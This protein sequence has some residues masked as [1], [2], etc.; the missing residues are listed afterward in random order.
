MLAISLE[1]C[2]RARWPLA[3]LALVL[4]FTA[5]PSPAAKDLPVKGGGWQRVSWKSHGEAEAGVAVDGGSGTAFRLYDDDWNDIRLVRRVRV[6]AGRFYRF[7]ARIRTEDVIGKVG[8]NLSVDGTYNR[9]RPG[10]TGTTGWTRVEQVFRATAS[11]RLAFALRLG[12]WNATARGTAW[13]DRVELEEL[14]SWGGSYEPVR[15]SPPQVRTTTAPPRLLAL[16]FFV[17]F[18][19]GGLAWL[20]RQPLALVTPPAGMGVPAR[21]AGFW[22]LLAAG[23]AVRLLFV[24]PPGPWVVPPA[25]ESWALYL[26]GFFG[27]GV[28]NPPAGV[29]VPP[30]LWLYWLGL[31]GSV[32]KAMVL[33]NSRAFA[34]LLQLP[35]VAIELVAVAAVL[36]RLRSG[37]T[38]G[39]YWA[40]AAF[41]VL[42]PG[43]L[44]A[45][46]LAADPAA[47]GAGLVL[48]SLLVVPGTRPV[49]RGM[50]FGA[51]IAAAPPMLWLAVPVVL[52]SWQRFGA[53]SAA[54]LATAAL[55][56]SGA[57][58]FPV[59]SF[60]EGETLAGFAALPAAGVAGGMLVVSG[61][62]LYLASVLVFVRRTTVQAAF[63]QESGPPGPLAGILAVTLT[64]MAAVTGPVSPLLWLA[65]LASGLLLAGNR[66][67][68]WTFFLLGLL[69]SWY[70][71][72]GY[73]YTAI[74][75]A[76]LPADSVV[77]AVLRSGIAALAIVS[78]WAILQPAPVVAA[79]SRWRARARELADSAKGL[80]RPPSARPRVPFRV[81]WFDLLLLTA[82]WAAGL[83]LVAHDMGERVYP[84]NAYRVGETS[85]VFEAVLR[86]PASLGEVRV[87][88]GANGFGDVRFEIEGEDGWEPLW[89]A[90]GGRLRYKGS[91][92]ERRS[93][94]KQLWRR[95]RLDQPVERVRLTLSGAGLEINEIVF[96]DKSREPL[97]P[98]VLEPREPAG[99]PVPASTHPLF[100]ESDRITAEKGYRA[101]TYWDEV[102][103][104][105]SGYELAN[106][107]TPYEK[108]HPP[109][110]K[111]LIAWGVDL[112]GMTP[113]GWRFMDAL[114]V[115][116]LPVLLWVA[117]RGIF[118][119]RLAAWWAAFLA[120]F[121]LMFFV[122]G[123]WAN[124]DTFLTVFLTVSLLALFRWYREG[125]GRFTRANVVWFV[126]AGFFFGCAVATKWSAL[127]TGFAIFVLW[128]I[129]QASAI[130]RCVTRPPA[131]RGPGLGTY[132]SRRLPASVAAWGAVF[133]A[134]PAVVYYLSYAGYL[135]SLPGSP[136]AFSTEG[137]HAFADQQ[138]FQWHFHAEKETGHRSSS[139]FFT[140]PLMLQPASMLTLGG[141][142]A[143]KT[144][145]LNILGNPVIWWSGLAA[146][147]ALGW[148]ALRGRDETA[149]F[150]AGIYFLQG[151][152]WLLVSRTTYLYHYL[153]FLPLLILGLVYWLVRLDTGR[154]PVQ[155]GLAVFALLVVG[156]FA[157][158]YPYVTG[159]P[160]PAG[161]TQAVRIFDGWSRL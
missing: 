109:L 145:T 85:E 54:R 75:T 1:K 5:A 14:E 4:L 140:W 13:F 60:Y 101:K 158:Y 58:V 40:V 127:F 70:W 23:L 108:S 160:V 57:L 24:A 48:L 131:D 61:V 30:P 128:A 10:V 100:D 12:Y 91:Q 63:A 161:Y 132:L 17:P 125:Q 123:R 115:S 96:L 74:S 92:R 103:Y 32:V 124:I 141:V 69:A 134:L 21:A 2:R 122:H 95:V 67:W 144:A 81:A 78:W 36:A 87:Y 3:L 133:V 49:L 146:M 112:F 98:L 86:A 47:L 19:Y 113:F 55:A 18:L 83:F 114:F 117:A 43:L 7:S 59:L 148:R 38:G 116:M 31:A 139:L 149:V 107:L 111:V 6:K 119:S 130:A 42:H 68:R 135:A 155:A 137:W 89:K 94:F 159:M 120:V 45:T 80:L 33:E 106:G 110:G 129:A 64:L 26:A 50:L 102:Y 51:G 105:R 143:G 88:T 118:G 151:L 152:P 39:A 22:A 126:A 53:G 62:V 147:L 25:A 73:Y 66:P 41:L 154:R 90:D 44:L 121:E 150:L 56:A 35:A 11:E 142:P 77:P 65:V 72:Y 20:R 157:V 37:V 28:A 136:A 104:A 84:L 93:T 99:P 156:G 76:G 82:A 79:L 52:W 8:A 9:S 71:G 97:V 15:P 16:L 46:G 29:A 138:V 153:P 27:Q 34:V